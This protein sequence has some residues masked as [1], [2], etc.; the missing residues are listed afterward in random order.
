M[1]ETSD[2]LLQTEKQLQEFK[3]EVEKSQVP[4]ALEAAIKTMRKTGLY[5]YNTD[6]NMEWPLASDLLQM[7]KNFPMKIRELKY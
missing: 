3:F 6:F 7:A 1:K 2:K 4:R 5:G